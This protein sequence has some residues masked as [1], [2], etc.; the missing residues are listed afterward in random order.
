MPGSLNLEGHIGDH[1]L[2]RLEGPD[3]LA[4]LMPGLGI[5][6]GSIQ[7]GWAYPGP[8]R[9]YRF[10]RDPEYSWDFKS[11]AFLAKK[12]FPGHYA[13]LEK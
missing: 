7:A 1:P 9:R 10:G 5:T 13:I 6:D 11:L 4:E 12:V 3:G 8:G 2:Y